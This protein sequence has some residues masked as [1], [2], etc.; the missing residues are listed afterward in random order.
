MLL[1]NHETV[2][3]GHFG[4]KKLM[5][6][7]SQY[8]YWPQMKADIFKVRELCVTSLSIHCQ[9]RCPRPSLKIIPVGKPFKCIGMH[10]KEFDVSEKGNRYTLV[11]QDY[12]TKW[13]EVQSD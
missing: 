3:A 4:P 9:E 6:H 11:F 8:Y 12:F 5:Q 10:F 1:E 7:V 2:F 13:L